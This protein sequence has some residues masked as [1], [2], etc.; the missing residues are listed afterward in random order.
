M[1]ERDVP[2]PLDSSRDKA[3]LSNPDMEPGSSE[4]IFTFSGPQ[5]PA[6]WAIREDRRATC[7]GGQ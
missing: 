3:R 1:L 6:C 7:E 5:L 2:G 4:A